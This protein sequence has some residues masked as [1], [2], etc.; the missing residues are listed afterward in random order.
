MGNQL[1]Q[2]AERLIEFSSV[3]DDS[4]VYS[5]LKRAIDDKLSD[6]GGFADVKLIG[7]LRGL[8]ECEYQLKPNALKNSFN[9][10]DRE[11]TEPKLLWVVV[12]LHFFKND[13]KKIKKLI[14]NGITS[15]KIYTCI[16]QFNEL[17][18]R[19]PHEKKIKESYTKI[20]QTYE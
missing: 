3:A 15:Q 5:T 6:N 1:T 4:E 18:E 8:I 12:S 2:F 20:I 17:S 7:E 16:K 10:K 13:R 14:S 11:L 19:I 9:L